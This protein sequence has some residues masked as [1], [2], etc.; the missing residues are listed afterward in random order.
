MYWRKICV[1][2]V[3]WAMVAVGAA[4]GQTFAPPQL[5]VTP[6]P[7]GSGARALGR[8][9]AFSGVADDATSASWNPAGLVQ[10]ARAELSLVGSYLGS[11]YDNTPL[12][13]NT[14]IGRESFERPDLNYASVVLPAF[15]IPVLDLNARV[16]FNYQQV[17]D[18]HTRLSF[19]QTITS[20]GTGGLD[21]EI[22]HTDMESRG[23]TCA[24]TPAFAVAVTPRF[25]VGAAVNFHRDEMFRDKAWVLKTESRAE[26]DWSRTLTPFPGFSFTVTSPFNFRY[27]NIEE[28]EGYHGINNTFGL[29]WNVWR[30]PRKGKKSL[31]I[32]GTIETPYE[33]KVIRDTKQFSEMSVFG[34][35]TQDM[36][37]VREKLV[38]KMPMSATFGANFRMSDDWSISGDF[39]WTNWSNFKQINESIEK[40]NPGRRATPIGGVPHGV[41]D[42]REQHIADTFGVRLGTEYLIRNK[43]KNWYIPC[44]AGVLWEQRPSLGTAEDY[45]GFA[46]GSGFRTEHVS[47][48]F[49]YQFRHASNVKG[50]DLGLWGGLTKYDV[51][52]HMLLAS[53]IIYFRP[54]AR[55]PAADIDL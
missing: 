53:V 3:C 22:L 23:A 25:Y 34:T 29:M 43:H 7:V 4:F 32:S 19:D 36:T 45:I 6:L 21:G 20:D 28:F 31:T 8:A 9:G 11:K 50:R 37:R 35:T 40:G 2:T 49:A 12:S 52:E 54:R 15:K 48:D 38:F 42:T 14:R 10:L 44:R 55:A 30:Q 41:G 18:M 24:L 27:R 1:W 51:N 5:T 13:S 16:S 26:G 33:A 47:F 46:L 39:Q 17:Y